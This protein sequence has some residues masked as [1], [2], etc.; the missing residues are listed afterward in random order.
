[1]KP[2]TSRQGRGG[3]PV[4]R[5]PRAKVERKKEQRGGPRGRACPG[6]RSAAVPPAPSRPA[7]PGLSLRGAPPGPVR[8]GAAILTPPAAAEALRGTG[9][10]TG[11]APPPPP[12]PLPPAR[13]PE[14]RAVCPISASAPSRTALRPSGAWPGEPGLAG[15][16]VPRYLQRK[17]CLCF[18]FFLLP[19]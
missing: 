18:L 14:Q 4:E 10:R 3:A 2:V 17:G 12:C 19:T 1:M 15:I 11:L 13:P 7:E 5:E 9:N 6:A 16:A 8:L